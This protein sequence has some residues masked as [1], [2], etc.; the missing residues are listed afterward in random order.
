MHDNAPFVTYK[1]DNVLKLK[2]KKNDTS[3]LN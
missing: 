2:K 1:R 3:L